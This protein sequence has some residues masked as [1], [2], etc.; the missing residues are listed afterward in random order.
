[1][2]PSDPSSL[3]QFVSVSAGYTRGAAGECWPRWALVLSHDG[4]TPIKSRDGRRLAVVART[5]SGKERP[6][7]HL[8]AVRHVAAVGGVT[9][10]ASGVVADW[11]RRNRNGSPLSPSSLSL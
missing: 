5:T 7:W 10:D 1:M 9:A 3:F 11:F 2:A 4:K 8:R 6:D